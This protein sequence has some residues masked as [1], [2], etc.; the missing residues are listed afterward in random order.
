MATVFLASTLSPTL[1][2]R[3][4]LRS[5]C[6]SLPARTNHQGDSKNKVKRHWFNNSFGDGNTLTWSERSH[7]EER[8][9]P[10]P[11]DGEWDLVRPLVGTTL[12]SQKHTRGNELSDNPA[13]IKNDNQLWARGRHED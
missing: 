3:M 2:R 7:D 12:N 9:R 1:A 10:H 5:A 4:T 11:L 8:D 13:L 6:S